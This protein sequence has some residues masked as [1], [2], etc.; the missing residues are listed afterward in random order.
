MGITFCFTM[1]LLAQRFHLE[2]K[3]VKLHPDGGGLLRP[4]KGVQI[5]HKVNIKPTKG[6]EEGS[7]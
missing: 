5:F 6:F 3:D 1:D 4:N 2:E 7:Q